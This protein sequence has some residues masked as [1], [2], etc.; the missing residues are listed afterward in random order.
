M[1]SFKIQL[2]VE[3]NWNFLTYLESAVNPKV[4]SRVFRSLAQF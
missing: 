1:K 2:G 3:K 4:L